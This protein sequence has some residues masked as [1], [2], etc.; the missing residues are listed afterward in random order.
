MNMKKI[1]RCFIALILMAA[2]IFYALFKYM[3]KIYLT[4]VF[5]DISGNVS[6][7]DA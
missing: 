6:I 3:D 1:L 2:F 7:G 5:A 4:P